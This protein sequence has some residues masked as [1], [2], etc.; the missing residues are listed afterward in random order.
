LRVFIGVFSTPS[1]THAERACKITRRL[2]N[3]GR[4]AMQSDLQRNAEELASLLMQ[5]IPEKH[6]EWRLR[7]APTNQIPSMPRLGELAESLAKESAKRIDAVEARKKANLLIIRNLIRCLFEHSWLV[8]PTNWNNFKDGDYLK[9]LGITKRIMQDAIEVLT[10]HES[11]NRRNDANRKQAGRY[12]HLGNIGLRVGNDVRLASQFRATEEL[13]LLFCGLLYQDHGGWGEAH[14]EI[15]P[16]CTPEELQHHQKQA[17][18]LADYNAFIQQHSFA[19]KGPM[20][21][22]FAEFPD[23]GGRITNAF[24]NLA[25]RRVPIRQQTLI[26]GEAIAEPD[27]SANHLRMAAYLCDVELPDDPY[28]AIVEHVE[29][30]T[31]DM[32]KRAVTACMGAQDPAQFGGMKSNFHRRI[33]GGS[34]ERLEAIRNALYQE[35]PFTKDVFFRDVGAHLQYLEGEVA[36]KMMFWAMALGVPLLP[37]HD[38]FAVPKQWEE[39]TE[40]SMQM[41][42]KVVMRDAR[43]SGDL[44]SNAGARAPA[45][46][47]L[48]KAKRRKH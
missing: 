4:T 15:P 31:R 36:L 44:I 46:Y 45:M 9:Q 47:E 29:G 22:S 20:T 37:V 14:Y 40:R 10:G 33:Q 30:A 35:Y 21:R 17:K 13:A 8:L 43:A 16:G 19:L 41:C 42:W 5:A 28:S 18:V 32:V 3:H 38:S 25:Q 12:M 6:R 26:N 24:Q 39:E 23:R 1:V 11:D 34:A 27:F 48:S 7:P 2:G